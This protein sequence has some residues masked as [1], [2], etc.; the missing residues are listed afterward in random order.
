MYNN[1]AQTFA[2]DVNN[3][4]DIVIDNKTFISFCSIF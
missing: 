3:S 2:I 4:N 1:M